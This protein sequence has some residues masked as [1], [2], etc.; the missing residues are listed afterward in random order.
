MERLKISNGQR[1]RSTVIINNAFCV[2]V[3]VCLC[4]NN[5]KKDKEREKEM[6]G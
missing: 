6:M 5:R 1:Y 3:R 4:L 2:R